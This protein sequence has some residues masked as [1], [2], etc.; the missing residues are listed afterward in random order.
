MNAH[1]ARE[2]GIPRSTKGGNSSTLRE[3]DCAIVISTHVGRRI[4]YFSYKIV[5][6]YRKIP[7]ELR[8]ASMTRS[9]AQESFNTVRLTGLATEPRSILL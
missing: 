2:S 7:L 1:V 6:L 5:F 4:L 9:N 3:S 8:V